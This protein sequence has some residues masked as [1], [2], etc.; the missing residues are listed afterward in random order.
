MSRRPTQQEVSDCLIQ[1]TGGIDW[2]RAILGERSHIEEARDKADAIQHRDLAGGGKVR[3]W[4]FMGFTG[5]ASPSLRWGVKDWRMIWET[6]GEAA[7]SLFRRMAQCGGRP[8]RLDVQTTIA[9][10][11]PLTGL[12]N[13]LIPSSHRTSLLPTSHTRKAGLHSDSRGCWYGTVGERTDP[14]FWRVYD[15]G[16]ESGK[17]P[18]GTLWR[19]ELEAKKSLAPKLTEEA[20][21]SSDVPKWSEERVQSSWRQAGYWWPLPSRSPSLP[22]VK[23]DAQQPASV[24]GLL[25]WYGLSVKPTIPRVL[26]V[27]TVAEVLTALGLSDV[28]VARG[29]D[30]GD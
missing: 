3:P 15:K 16:V 13:C 10:S 23:A 30:S 8:T 28:A 19:I 2:Y 14:D 11:K 29:S 26:T 5:L 17:A 1:R 27:F 18:A 25:N 9:L 7:P 12:G 24:L 20:C 4:R 21:Q 22:P 6:S